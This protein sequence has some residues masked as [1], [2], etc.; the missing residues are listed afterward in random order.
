MKNLLLDGKYKLSDKHLSPATERLCQ[1]ARDSNIYVVIGINERYP[2]S[3][4][5]LYNFQLFIN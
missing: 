5:T 1:G 4:G 2:L 3:M